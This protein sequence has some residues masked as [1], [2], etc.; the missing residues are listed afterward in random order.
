LNAT[1]G[2]TTP[3]DVMTTFVVREIGATSVVGASVVDVVVVEDVDDDVVPV[4]K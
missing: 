1:T 2:A 3:V 4:G